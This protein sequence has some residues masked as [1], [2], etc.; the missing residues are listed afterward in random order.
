MDRW[1]P[2]AGLG[3]GRAESAI[4]LADLDRRLRRHVPAV[5][6]RAPPLLGR[7]GRLLRLRRRPPH[8]A[9]PGRARR[10]RSALP[11]ALFMLTGAVVAIDNLFGRARVIV[12]VETE[13][14]DEAELRRRYDAAGRGDR[15]ARSSGCASGAPPAP[16]ALGATPDRRPGVRE[17]HLPGRVR[18]AGRAAS[19]STSAP[20]TPSRSCSRS[21][22]ASRCAADALRPLPRAA[23]PES[24]PLPL[25]PGPR[26]LP[27]RRLLARGAGA[28]GGR[29]GGRPPHR[30]HPPPRRDRRGG[31]RP[32]RRPPRRPQG[33]RR[34]PHAPRPRPQRRRPRRPLRH[35]CASRSRWSSRSTPT[36]STWSPPSR[37]SCARGS[38][39][40]TSSAPPS[41]P[42]PS[43]APPRCAPWRS[44]TSW[45]PSRRGPYAGAVGYL[46]HGGR[47]MDLAIAIRTVV[48]EDGRAH[49]QAGRRHRR[50]LRPRRG[51]R[52]D[53]QQ[54][55]GAAARRAD[56]GRSEWVGNGAIVSGARALTRMGIPLAPEEGM[57]RTE[58]SEAHRSA[59]FA[60]S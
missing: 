14:A 40:S 30:R 28:G 59:A 6:A 23:H 58:M 24:L 39:P 17:Q 4:P 48:A 5:G 33:A 45:S 43:P 29:P 18:G 19:R 26:R 42:A 27:A 36:S 55:A 22:S 10:R 35:A 52:G 41:P 1:T 46:A 15:R 3:G 44:S 21:G 56:G 31:R 11:D 47:A 57:P 8:R 49:V 34:A 51:V 53:P 2:A 12:A 37:A 38:P 7:R 60:C 50:R 32:L 20:A 13:G 9:A 25:L 54:G 16:L